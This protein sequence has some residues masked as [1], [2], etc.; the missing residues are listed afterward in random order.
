MN[1][2]FY[3]PDSQKRDNTTLNMYYTRNNL[4]TPSP[5]KDIDYQTEA[6][7]YTLALKMNLKTKKKKLKYKIINYIGTIGS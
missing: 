2:L 4:Q 7:R 5:K 6:R 1:Y 3:R